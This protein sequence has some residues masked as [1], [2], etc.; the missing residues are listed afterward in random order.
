MA[1]QEEESFF[2]GSPAKKTQSSDPFND[3]LTEQSTPDK[4][5]VVHLLTK[6]NNSDDNT[7]ISGEGL[8]HSEEPSDFHQDVF[9][10]PFC[11]PTQYQIV[12]NQHIGK[13]PQTK[14]TEF[15]SLFSQ[16]LVLKSSSHSTQDFKQTK[17]FRDIREL[18]ITFSELE[19]KPAEDDQETAKFDLETPSI[20]SVLK[21]LTN[22]YQGLEL[23]RS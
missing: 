6:V 21:C 20:N 2:F 9:A 7:S 13:K 1:Q 14:V 15:E 22:V 19:A 18:A 10:D 17:V 5:G 8:S 16:S 12:P 11:E 3:A 23:P 4:D